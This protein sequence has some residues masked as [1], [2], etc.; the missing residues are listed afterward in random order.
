[1]KTLMRPPID[2]RGDANAGLFVE[3]QPP[4]HLEGHE[5]KGQ[6]GRGV[7][8]PRNRPA[9][10]VPRCPELR[11]AAFPSFRYSSYLSCFGPEHYWRPC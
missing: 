9:Q 3:A 2:R 4:A 10:L 5:S 6:E 8:S 1:M 11:G 7:R